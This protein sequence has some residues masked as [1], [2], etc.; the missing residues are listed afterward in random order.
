M[1]NSLDGFYQTPDFPFNHLDYGVYS[2]FGTILAPG[3]RVFLVRGNGTTTTEYT[4]D[5]PGLR[6]RLIPSI[7]KALTYCVAGRGDTIY[8]LEGHTENVAGANAWT[9]LVAGTKII[10]RGEGIQRP[11]LTWSAAASQVAVSKANVSI[12]NMQMLCAGPAGTT[13]ITVATPFAITAAGFK[14][15]GNDVEA[16]VDADQIVTNM[17]T[18]SAAADDCRFGNNV[19]HAGPL[20]AVT[21]ILVTAGAVDR[22]KIYGN[23]ISVPVT[24]AATGVLLDLSN[25]AMIDNDIIGNILANTTASSV[26]VIKPHATSTGYVHNNL[27]CTGDAGTAPASSAWTTFTTTY[28]FG[29]NYCVTTTAKSAIL[30]PAADS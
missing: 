14:F 11:I 22:L 7:T 19:I 9:D 18:L 17:M 8:V 5:T 23:R 13:A 24:T 29:L 21:T 28:Q 16:G 25:A 2:Q 1:A 30:C 20:S 26:N 10:G 12:A 15:I 3:G 4:Y 27:W 6:E